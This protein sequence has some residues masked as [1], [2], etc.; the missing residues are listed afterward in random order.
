MPLFMRG[1]G[2][3]GERGLGG[4][5]EPLEAWRRCVGHISVDFL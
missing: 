5:L 3:N 1:S 4:A 2:P